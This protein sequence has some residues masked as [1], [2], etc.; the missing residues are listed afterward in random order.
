MGAPICAASSARVPHPPQSQHDEAVEQ[1]TA[2]H[3][4]V[5]RSPHA[6]VTSEVVEQDTAAHEA[7][8]DREENA[9][10]LEVVAL[11]Q[12]ETLPRPPPL[13]WGPAGAR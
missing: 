13:P 1:D 10:A 11:E 12:R 4:V 3:D 5:E 9:K 7:V 6:D 2:A 8:D